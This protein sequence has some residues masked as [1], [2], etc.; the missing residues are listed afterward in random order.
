MKI[1]GILQ[2]L[3]NS[4]DGETRFRIIPAATLY[5]ITN[6]GKCWHRILMMEDGYYL[7]LR[8]TPPLNSMFE[9]EWTALLEEKIQWGRGAHKD[10]FTREL[11]ADVVRL[12]HHHLGSP[13]ADRLLTGD[14]WA[15]IEPLWPTG[16]KTS[17]EVSDWLARCGY[18]EGILLSKMQKNPQTWA[19]KHAAEEK[20]RFDER[21]A[22]IATALGDAN[23]THQP[24]NE[25][26]RT[27]GMSLE[28]HDWSYSYSD[29]GAT[30]KRGQAHREELDR[31]LRA[32]PL[33]RAK[34]VWKA[35][36]LPGN[37]QYWPRGF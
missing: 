13:A 29:C 24:L 7:R 33:E 16:Y 8:L 25:T 19:E 1:N 27:L 17:Y 28:S 36:V 35:F 5:Q 20:R 18:N 32:L 10:S 6:Y 15:D 34:I 3:E 37:E 11:P 14:L 26:E 30:W 23:A 9:S 2:Q 22:R 4:H 31:G 21:E 12:M